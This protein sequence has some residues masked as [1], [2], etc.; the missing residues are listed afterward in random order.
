MGHTIF[1]PFSYNMGVEPGYVK[2]DYC[3]VDMSFYADYDTARDLWSKFQSQNFDDW[4]PGNVI[5]KC[6]HCGQWGARKTECKKCGA[7]ID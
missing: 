5:V 1:Q 6:Q 7:P 4:Y 2:R 3:S